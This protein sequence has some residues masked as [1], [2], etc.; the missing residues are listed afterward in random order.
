MVGLKI[1]PKVFIDIYH[2]L[3][4]DQ[5]GGYFNSMME[6]GRTCRLI[7]T[8]G[9]PGLWACHF[10]DL[11]CKCAYDEHKREVITVGYIEGQLCG[12][13]PIP[14]VQCFADNEIRIAKQMGKGKYL[15]MLKQKPKLSKCPTM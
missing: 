4:G 14:V 1:S 10:P 13:E 7:E 2:T 6:A 8:K 12:F 5:K 15:E 3:H 11:W 9:C